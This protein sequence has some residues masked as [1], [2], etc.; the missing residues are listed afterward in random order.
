MCGMKNP[1]EAQIGDTFFDPDFP[2][3][4]LPG[5]KKAK[6]VVFGGMFPVDQS[7]Y[8]GLEAALNRLTLNDRSVTIEPAISTVLGKVTAQSW[9]CLS[10]CY[11]HSF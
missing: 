1:S 4:A 7:E 2:V 6:P 8:K 9:R 10:V 3:S 11:W 5:F